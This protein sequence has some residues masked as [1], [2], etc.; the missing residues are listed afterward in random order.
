ME[1]K[2]LH[3]DM[4]VTLFELDY[5]I[6]MYEEQFLPGTEHLGVKSITGKQ[7][8]MGHW[9]NGRTCQIHFSSNIAFFCSRRLEYNPFAKSRLVHCQ[10]SCS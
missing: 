7:L 1:L 5:V 3:P 9:G 2:R 8:A 6:K 10:S 4:D